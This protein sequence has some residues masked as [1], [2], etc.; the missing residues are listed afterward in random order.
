VRRKGE[1]RV[2]R[3]EDGQNRPL[4]PLSSIFHPHLQKL[5]RRPPINLYL[6]VFVERALS[7]AFAKEPEVTSFGALGIDQPAFEGLEVFAV[8]ADA[9]TG[10][11]VLVIVENGSDIFE[12]IRIIRQL[13]DNVVINFGRV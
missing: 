13:D 2:L 10:T 8:S 4:N 1:D 6:S 3:I 11:I 12:E 7:A 9:Q 5:L